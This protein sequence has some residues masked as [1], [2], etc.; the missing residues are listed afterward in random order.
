MNGLRSVT[1]NV[2]VGKK[3]DSFWGTPQEGKELIPK[4][5]LV[6]LTEDGAETVNCTKEIL[7]LVKEFETYRFVLCNE[8]ANKKLKIVDIVLEEMEEPLPFTEK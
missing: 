1:G 8:T 5:Q 7:D 6:L 3:I 4:R 2:I